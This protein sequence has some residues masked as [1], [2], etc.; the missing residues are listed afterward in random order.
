MLLP[1]LGNAVI[2]EEL[3]FSFR[4]LVFGMS[5]TVHRATLGVGIEAGQRLGIGSRE[6]DGT[7]R[8]TRWTFPHVVLFPGVSGSGPR[9]RPCC[10]RSRA[11]AMKLR[12]QPLGVLAID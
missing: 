10:E 12:G 9:M 2:T 7:G 11:A 4:S 6:L 3:A 8:I 1:F 5:A